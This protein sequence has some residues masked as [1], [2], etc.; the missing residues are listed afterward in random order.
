[1]FSIQPDLRGIQTMRSDVTVVLFSIFKITLGDD[2]GPF[3]YAHLQI[4]HF[5][6]CREYLIYCEPVQ[7]TLC[8]VYCVYLNFPL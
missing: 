1:M 4:C 7:A 3:G 6:V 5:C 8:R 2:E